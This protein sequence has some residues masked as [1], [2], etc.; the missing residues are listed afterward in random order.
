MTTRLGPDEILSAFEA[1]KPID[2]DL[3]R[4]WEPGRS[5]RTLQAVLGQSGRSAIIRARTGRTRVRTQRW[6]GVGIVVAAALAV[7]AM[8]AAPAVLR[9]QSGVPAEP[10]APTSP[11]PTPSQPPSSDASV[12]PQ[13]SAAPSSPPVARLGVGSPVEMPFAPYVE[14]ARRASQADIDAWFAATREPFAEQQ[15]QIALCMAD[16]GFDYQ[17]RTL[18]DYPVEGTVLGALPGAD[19]RLA[20]LPATRD[21]VARYGYGQ[22]AGQLGDAGYPTNEYAETLAWSKREAP[23]D[24][25]SPA[26][27]AN[28]ATFERLS[29]AQQQDFMVVLAICGGDLELR[30]NHPAVPTTHAL[31]S[32]A[33]YVADEYPGSEGRLD[34]LYEYEPILQ[35]LFAILL[36]GTHLT[37]LDLEA[38]EA[39]GSLYTDPRV[40]AL[41]SAWTTCMIGA[42]VVP[43]TGNLDRI[44][45][46]GPSS[47]TT[48]LPWFA[49]TDNGVTTL[50]NEAYIAVALADFD[51]RGQTDYVNTL[52]QVQ[53]ELEARVVTAHQSELDTLVN[54]WN[55]HR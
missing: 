8:I 20:W 13:E 30:A 52:A 51:C 12:S 18:P 44:N 27:R 19:L 16:S 42:G 23:L 31:S 37:D 41:N 55:T 39:A 46:V 47:P 3:Q 32:R 49:T 26:D 33:D 22:L 14:I 6:I 1:L 35:P 45:R 28:N 7:V 24:E 43:E 50:S 38:M 54:T 4:A 9:S 10:A 5:E 11:L 48:L 21:Q 40:T 36:T 15:K 25:W 29:E 2:D 34:W 53:A 17:A